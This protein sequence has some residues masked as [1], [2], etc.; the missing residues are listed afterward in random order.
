MTKKDKK[1]KAKE[2]GKKSEMSKHYEQLR[3]IS[4]ATLL[5]ESSHVKLI[6]RGILF[7]AL[8]I[9]AFIIWSA[10]VS[11]KE[12][13]TT[14]GELVP[15]GNVQRVQHLEGGIVTKV[16]VNNGDT[17]K[18]GQLLVEFNALAQQSELDNLRSKEISL[19]LDS[20]RLNAFLNNKPANILQW[21]D[22][23]VESKYNPVK[24]RAQIET[25]LN[26]QKRFLE[27]QY[28]SVQTQQSSLKNT[29][30]QRQEKLKELH[31][32]KQIW[33]KHIS[34]LRKEFS[35]YEKLKKNN[36]VSHKDYLT[37]LR[38]V[39]TAKGDGAR[40]DSEIEQTEELIEEARYK[41]KEVVVS[42]REESLEQLSKINSELLSVRHQIEKLDERIQR[43]NVVSP[44]GGTVKGIV[45]S[46]GNVVKPGGELLEVV[47]SS[48]ELIAESRVLPREIGHIQKGDEVK[49]KILTYDY[50]RYGA[51]NGKLTN[52]SATTFDDEEGKPYYRATITLE[53][54]FLGSEKYRRE[55]RPGMTVQA[56][57]VTGEKTLLQY[58]MKPIHRSFNESFKER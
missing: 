9:I 35:M 34:L 23:V 6:Y 47:P 51:I 2:N 37:V 36:Y 7:V 43:A 5:E 49:V 29:L 41:F 3:H 25:L 19:S 22:R 26:D 31:K 12:M 46:A 52:I 15:K 4:E 45:V 53:S 57:I 58:L 33:E 20:Y 8:L 27:S 56:D 28:A 48:S 30:L 1:S 10:F 11:L 24:Q 54:Q 38:A 17:V 18:R 44:V 50:A 40:I 39:N 21:A 13:T 14:Y 32:Q 42:A 16:L 55:L